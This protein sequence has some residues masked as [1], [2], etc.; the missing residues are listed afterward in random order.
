MKYAVEMGSAAMKYMTD[1]IR[2]SSGIQKLI[3]GIHRHT[4]WWINK[5]NYVFSRNKESGLKQKINFWVHSANRL[6][7]T[8]AS[9]Q[10]YRAAV[11]RKV[12]LSIPNEIIGFFIWPNPSNRTVA[13]RSTQP[14]TEM[15]TRNLPGGT[16][17]PASKADLTAICEPIF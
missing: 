5:P 3:R 16:G 9:L 10:L 4:E 6:V 12:A 14:L 17:R 15:S 11:S 7:A 13:L 8:R 2:I 1:F